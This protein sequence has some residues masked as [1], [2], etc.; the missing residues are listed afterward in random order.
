MFV[1]AFLT[2]VGIGHSIFKFVV[3]LP[4]P[5][6]LVGKV[7]GILMGVGLRYLIGLYLWRPQ[8][9]RDTGRIFVEEEP[10]AVRAGAPPAAM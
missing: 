2:G 9:V 8:R 5:F 7:D 10:G 1:P 6:N 4:P 3:K